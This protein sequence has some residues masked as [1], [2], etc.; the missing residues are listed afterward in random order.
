MKKIMKG[1]FLAAG[2]V[3]SIAV[4]ADVDWKWDA[5][6][7]V[8]AVPVT[9]SADISALTVP[10]TAQADDEGFL[11]TFCYHWTESAAFRLTG[12]SLGLFLIVQ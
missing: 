2:A 1:F 10:L 7:H 4:R 3:F 6:Q 9:A 11:S 5:S 8:E 12:G